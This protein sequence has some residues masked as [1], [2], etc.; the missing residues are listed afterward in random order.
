MPRSA[1]EAEARSVR[2][3]LS[4]DPLDVDKV[5]VWPTVAAMI[6]RARGEMPRGDF[7]VLCTVRHLLTADIVD[8][9]YRDV[10]D[11]VGALCGVPV[12]KWTSGPEVGEPSG[13]IAGNRSTI[14]V[15]DSVMRKVAGAPG[16]IR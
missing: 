4:V 6:D 5:S 8:G 15:P 2:W 12:Q 16:A 7:L 10:H 9:R 1:F 3:H 11:Q 13:A 14:S